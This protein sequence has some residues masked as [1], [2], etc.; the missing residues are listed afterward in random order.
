M[1]PNAKH[2]GESYPVYKLKYS[3]VTSR[4]AMASKGSVLDIKCPAERPPSGWN[5]E[6]VGKTK[7]LS[8]ARD[9][10]SVFV[11]CAIKLQ[12]EGSG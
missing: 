8:R 5:I 11:L 2:N 9:G 10:G 6:V 7:A 12:E 3:M 1:S 4:V